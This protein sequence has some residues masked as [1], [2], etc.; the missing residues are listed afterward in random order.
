MKEKISRKKLFE[1]FN[2]FYN[3]YEQ[4]K[5]SVSSRPYEKLSYVTRAEVK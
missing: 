3:I 2:K 5:E 4:L 1:T